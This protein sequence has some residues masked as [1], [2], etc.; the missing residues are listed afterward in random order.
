[1]SDWLLPY[2][3]PYGVG[4]PD[5][6]GLKNVIP[7]FL[8]EEYS[9]DDDLQAFVDAQNALTQQFLD[10]FNVVQ[11]PVYTSDQITGL[12][13]DWVGAGLYGFPR[14]SILTGIS[15]R[16]GPYGTT[17]YGQPPIAYGKTKVSALPTSEIVDDDIYKRILTWHFYKADGKYFAIKWLKKRVMRF[18]IGTDGTAPNIDQTYQISVT[19]GPNREANIVVYNSLRRSYSGPGVYGRGRAYGK[20]PS[21]GV[22]PTATQSLTPF[23]A[24]AAFKAC[25][26]SGILEVPFQWT[27]NV[28]IVD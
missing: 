17:W 18:L 28:V 14:P 23:P 13:L 27:W 19:F 1:M 11:L 4:L 16:L 22:A 3:W 26:E 9:D 25:F 20:G 8:Y 12:L 24:A 2:P 7:S 5:S 6:P 15:R 10:W 21:Y